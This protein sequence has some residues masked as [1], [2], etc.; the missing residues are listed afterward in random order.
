MAVLISVKGFSSNIVPNDSD[1]PN[2]DNNKNL[3]ERS[4][5][6]LYL[7]LILCLCYAFYTYLVYD[8][9]DDIIQAV[10]SKRVDGMFLDRYRASYYQSKGKLQSLITVKKLE[11]H[12]EVGILFSKNNQELAKC[13]GLFRSNIWRL[14]QVLTATFKVT[15]I[16]F[17]M[18]EST[19]ARVLLHL[20]STLEILNLDV[21]IHMD[22]D[23]DVEVLNFRSK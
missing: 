15:L 3:N 20:K 6:N 22:T 10:K 7:I 9:I 12:R 1:R 19:Q 17:C 16:V 4:E 23:I 8:E 21:K 14:F 11:F 2:A 18:I 5:L 13:L